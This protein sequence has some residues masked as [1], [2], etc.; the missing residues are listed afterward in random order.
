MP[1]SASTWEAP[2]GVARSLWRALGLVPAALRF[3]AGLSVFLVYGLTIA[4][5]GWWLG[6]RRL[7][8][9]SQ[10]MLRAS[11]RAVG[12]RIAVEGREQL[13]AREA[14]VYLFNHTS[15]LDHFVVTCTAPGFVVGVEKIENFRK[16]VYGRMV[17]WWGNIIVDRADAR[18]GIAA[19]RQAR[20]VLKSGA[21]VGLAPEGTR[22]A[23]GVVRAFKTGSFEIAS[24]AQ[25]P[26]VPVSLVNM[27]G[28]NPDGRFRL[29][30]GT[31]RIV[32]GPPIDLAACASRDDAMARVRAAMAA[33]G[34]TVAA[35]VESTGGLDEPLA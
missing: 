3:G 34:L 13:S 8:R 24:I 35:V 10:R 20:R 14:Y 26:I 21:S 1:A 29:R 28:C 2:R 33:A 11:L 19:I 25:R 17:R 9:Y 7:F 30:P 16:P 27:L 5:V 15:F 4:L 18:S 22:S 23:D 31:V 6:P 32:Y 12:M